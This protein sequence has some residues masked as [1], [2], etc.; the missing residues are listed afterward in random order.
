[1][2]S[3]RVII[4]IEKNEAQLKSTLNS[5]FEN[6]KRNADGLLKLVQVLL[7]RDI[8]LAEKS[9]DQYNKLKVNDYKGLSIKALI[10]NQK[11]EFSDAYAV[12][13]DNPDPV[14]KAIGRLLDHMHLMD[15][16]IVDILNMDSEI[17]VHSTWTVKMLIYSTWTVKLLI[18]SPLTVKFI[19]G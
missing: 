2:S 6:N 18:Y 8:D 4:Q 16:K 5:A 19:H 1:M 14:A 13:T 15:N 7:P 10:L 11:K 9:I 12:S 17:V 3:I